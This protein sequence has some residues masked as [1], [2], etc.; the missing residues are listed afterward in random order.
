ML[1]GCALALLMG[2]P[3][4]LLPQSIGPLHDDF[5][6]RAARWVVC[7]AALTCV[8]ERRSLDLLQ[9]LGCAQ[10]A[11]RLPDMAF[12]APSGTSPAQ[13]LLDHAGRSATAPAFRVGMT[14]LNWSGQNFTFTGQETYE[15]A[16]LGCI[17]TLTA[18][19]G[20]VVL[21][22]QCCGPSAAE[23][24]RHVGARLRARA[25]MPDR[26]LLIAEPLP[27]P[28]LQA[29]YGQMDYFIGTRMHSVILAL[30]AGVPALAIGYLHKT[31]GV[32]EELGMADRCYDINTLTAAELIDGFERLR[33][34]APL[35]ASRSISTRPARQ[36]RAR[37]A[38]LDVGGRP[39]SRRIRVV[40][41]V[42]GLAVGEYNGGGEMF[43][44]RLAQALDPQRF[45][46]AVCAMWAYDLRIE[47]DWQR[48]LV[49]QG[50]P[51][52][53]GTHYRAKFRLDF[54]MAFATSYRLFRKLRP[55]IL[56]T[57]TEYPDMV[58]LAIKLAGGARIMVRTGHNVIEWPFAPEIA[59]RL[60]WLYPLFCAREVG[61]SRS[62]VEILINIRSRAC[63][64]SVRPI[65]QTRSSPR[66]CWP[67]APIATCALCW[68]C[69]KTYRCLGSLAGLAIR[70]ACPT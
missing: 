41:F 53:F 4:V 8:R 1:S 30:N 14:V 51:T 28:A 65:F 48:T 54:E 70:R 59:R 57:H 5:Q 43:A 12:G 36:A 62:V 15:D 13:A 7:H 42:S 31:S 45:D 10:R 38:D 9:Q 44:I 35:L 66:F 23:D 50:I 64:I 25:S 63:C 29:A 40:Q 55:D 46:V 20:E 27:P 22:A 33:C 21:F 49:E 18:Q 24:D 47:R 67:N 68:A 26:V 6:R 61:V 17:D 11:L 16:M 19:G 39:M 58:G 2:K 69:Q 3:L 60:A 56:N 37:P 52:Y 34:A 32:L